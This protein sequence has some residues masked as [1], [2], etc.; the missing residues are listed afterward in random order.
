MSIIDRAHLF[1]RVLPYICRQPDSTLNG[2]TAIKLFYRDVP[3]Y[4]VDID[5]IFLPSGSYI[6][7]LGS[8]HEKLDMI[9]KDIRAK[10]A[11]GSLIVGSG[12]ASRESPEV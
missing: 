11:S 10:K 2:G 1:A 12:P 9:A 4:S 6:E 3:R 5:L 8:I 7:H